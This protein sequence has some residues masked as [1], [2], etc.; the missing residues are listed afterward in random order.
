M[1]LDEFDKLYLT[2]CTELMKAAFKIHFWS[3]QTVQEVIFKKEISMHQ[4]CFDKLIDD[5]I[6]QR[7]AMIT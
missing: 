2:K 6:C 3:L 4:S 7:S 5:K 1:C